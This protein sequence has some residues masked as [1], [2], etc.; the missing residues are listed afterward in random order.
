MDVDWLGL[1]DTAYLLRVAGRL[2][3]AAL[4]GGLIGAQ[5]EL[6][7]KAAGLRTHMT[8]SLAAATFVMVAL[9]TSGGSS[10]LGA[11]IQGIATGVGFLGAGTIL[12]KSSDEDIQGLTTA[13]TIWLTAAIGVAAGA[14]HG[15]LAFFVV[16]GAW[17]ILSIL[18]R[19]SRWISPNEDSGN[20][21][22]RRG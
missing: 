19:T 17:L 20:G 13:A 1:P 6:Q 9:E 3:C 7:G 15:W 2:G 16:L 18:V 8:V 10:N 11:V 14:G 5:R 4:L 21:K 22:P 12:K